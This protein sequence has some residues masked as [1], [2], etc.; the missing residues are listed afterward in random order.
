[1]LFLFKFLPTIHCALILPISPDTLWKEIIE[2]LFDDFLAFFLP[3]LH[4]EVDASREPQFL[5]QELHQ[6]IP[7]RE[8]K[9]KRINDK[10]VKVYLKSGQEK[11]ILVHI[12]VQGEYET[13]FSERMF[14]YYYRIFD[15]YRQEITAIALFT[16]K[17]TPR[18]Y[19]RYKT[20]VFGTSILYHY[21][22]IRIKD[23]QEEDLIGAENP[24]ALAVLAGL[25][26]LKTKDQHHKRMQFKFRLIRLALAQNYDRKKIVRLFIFVRYLLTLPEEL[27]LVFEQGIRDDLIQKENKMT[28]RPQDKEFV[29]SLVEAMFGKS[30]QAMEEEVEEVREKQKKLIAKLYR[31]AHFSVEEIVTY[32]ESSPEFIRETLR[33][34][35]LLS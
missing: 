30:I 19:D 9:G 14:V 35:G 4:V 22:A 16:G 23:Y 34:Q 27:E 20:T 10:L 6:I 25:Y 15:K 1:M 2:D 17:K 12:E 33:E 3:D 5:E 13:N 8:R 24:F 7:S 26:A 31:D 32:L 21:N 28:V 29:N 11:W 18:K